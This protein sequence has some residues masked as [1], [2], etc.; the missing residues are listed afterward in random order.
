MIT[1]TYRGVEISYN[2]DAEAWVCELNTN[3]F[4]RQN[5]RDCKTAIDVFIDGEDKIKKKFGKIEVFSNRWAIGW[6]MLTIKSI[7]SNAVWL[8][9]SKGR[10]KQR[11]LFDCEHMFLNTP[12]NKTILENIKAKEAICDSLI[13]EVKQLTQTL[14]QLDPNKYL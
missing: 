6:E 8:S 7:T 2:E 4:Q 11:S 9:D 5:L 10:D 14:E 3:P 12:E 13:E 1:T